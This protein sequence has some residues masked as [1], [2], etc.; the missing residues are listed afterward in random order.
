MRVATS[1]K[2]VSKAVDENEDVL[3]V[4]KI[5]QVGIWGTFGDCYR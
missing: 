5:V 3:S 1:G 4:L 2:F